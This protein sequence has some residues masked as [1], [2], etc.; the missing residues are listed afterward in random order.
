MIL[1]LG[2]AL[3]LTESYIICHIWNFMTIYYGLIVLYALFPKGWGWSWSKLF[4]LT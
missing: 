2:K 1:V 3:F 4:G